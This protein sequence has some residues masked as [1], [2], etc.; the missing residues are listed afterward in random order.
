MLKNINTYFGNAYVRYFVFF[1][2][3][4]NLL[5]NNACKIDDTTLFL[6]IYD[7]WLHEFVMLKTDFK[8]LTIPD[9]IL[10]LTTTCFKV[11]F[12]FDVFLIK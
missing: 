11:L 9:S 10:L 8:Y 1:S 2:W 3:C 7:L 12:F 6:V 4:K 5:C